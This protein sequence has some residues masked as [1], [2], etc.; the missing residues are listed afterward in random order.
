M[1]AVNRFKTLLDDFVKTLLSC[2]HVH[3][4][5]GQLKQSFVCH[6]VS[7]TIA[8]LENLDI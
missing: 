2:V 8:T 6:S 4:Q 3:V 5:K 1:H 7:M